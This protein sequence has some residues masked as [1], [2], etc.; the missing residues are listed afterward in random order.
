MLQLDDYRHLLDLELTNA[1]PEPLAPNEVIDAQLAVLKH[2]V[3]ELPPH[4]SLPHPDDLH[5]Y[6][7][8]HRDHLLPS[9]LTIRD[10][11]ELPPLPADI[12]AQADALAQLRNNRNPDPYVPIAGIPAL[13]AALFPSAN[14]YS[15]PPSFP[16]IHFTRGD[17]TRLDARSLAGSSGTL[18]LVNPAN[19]RMLGCFK[20]SHP[21]ADN[22]I[23]AAAG[24]SLR[25]D[26]A[27][28]MRARGWRDVETAEAVIVTRGGALRAQYVL[29]VAG[30]QLARRGVSP[31][32]EQERQLETVYR[33]CLDL[34]EELGTIS[35]IAFPCI[36][37]GLFFFPGDLAAR[38]ALRTVSSWLD[39]HPAASSSV[40][41]VIFVLFS[42]TDTDNY[43]TA[44]PAVFPSLPCAP[45]PLPVALSLPERVKTWIRDADSVI[46]HA[47]A[48]LSADA[49]NEE[50]GLPLDYT[51]KALFARLYPGLVERTPLRCLYD[52]IGHEWDDPLVKWAFLLLHPLTVT[53]WA[54]PAPPRVYASLRRYASSRP[55]GLA[56]LTSNADNLFRS[57]GFPREAVHTPQGGYTH[58]Q[59][60]SSSCAATHPPEARVWPSLPSCEAA[61]RAGALDPASMR[62]PPRLAAEVIPRCP[63]CGGTE[64][65]W[66]VRG[67]D[68]FVDPPAP[69]AA[70]A[71]RVKALLERAR[72][73]GGHVLLLELGAGFNTPAVVRWPGEELLKREGA[74]GALKMVRV[75]ANAAHAQVGW[76]VEYPELADGEREGRGRDVAGVRMGAAE[77]TRVLEG[78]G[79]WAQVGEGEA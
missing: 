20:P 6:P 1:I 53:R 33:R 45:A 61:L 5:A 73:R 39:A 16:R 15:L 74:D 64:V 27:R 48:G 19:T 22:V 26:C 41:S 17:Y 79:W 24:P 7:S 69:A 51:S 65:F 63:A 23:H 31:T 44:L 25:A 46:I 59:C 71:A 29:H 52:T 13:P 66:H 50:I 68:W 18:A 76:E 4:P 12:L 55:G 35:T 67:G 10:P 60:L 43:L 62:I 36:S 28:V 8:S 78:E 47:G 77:F 34:A 49:V 9:L 57:S 37:T 40:K 14:P 58:F 75:N 11:Q 2:L 54:T 3:A 56:V 70:H 32:E 72:E 30:P 38:I 42:Q 21:C